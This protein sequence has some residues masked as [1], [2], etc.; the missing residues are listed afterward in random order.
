MPTT[1]KRHSITETELVQQALEPLRSAG[2][3]IDLPDLVRRG[4]EELARELAERDA[5]AGRRAEL[6]RLFLARA[7]TAEGI[8]LAAALDVRERG[9]TR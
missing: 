7:Q 6:R 5:E 1:R 9:W 8:D 4:A 3:S 2:V